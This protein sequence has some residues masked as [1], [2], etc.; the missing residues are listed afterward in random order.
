LTE[1]QASVQSEVIASVARK[2]SKILPNFCKK[3]PKYQNIY[4]KAGFQSPKPPQQTSVETL[5]YVQHK[6]CVETACLTENL[7]SKM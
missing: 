2:L 5:K 6:P 4:T 3:W 7:F 1:R